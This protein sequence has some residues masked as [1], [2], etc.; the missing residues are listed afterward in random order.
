MLS[1]QANRFNVPP[2]L[3]NQNLK[4]NR[5]TDPRRKKIRKKS[6]KQGLLSDDSM[7]AC[8]AYLAFQQNGSPELLM[9]VFFSGKGREERTSNERY[10]LDSVRYTSRVES[11][12]MLSSNFVVFMFGVDRPGTLR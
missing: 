9:S 10:F 12:L 1:I 11:P 2:I 7:S 3:S 4:K 5:V 6:N 8:T